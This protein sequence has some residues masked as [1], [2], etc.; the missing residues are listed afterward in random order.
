MW[1]TLM[2]TKY[3]WAKIISIKSWRPS[4]RE[5]L[6]WTLNPPSSLTRETKRTIP[7]SRPPEQNQGWETRIQTRICPTSCGDRERVGRE[8][9]HPTFMIWD[10]N[11]IFLHWNSNKNSKHY[12]NLC[13]LSVL[14]WEVSVSHIF[15][16]L[17]SRNVLYHVHLIVYIL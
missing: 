8:H 6:P 9:T 15:T 13:Y 12:H 7:L 17:N 4:A 1:K 10:C 16:N 11:L 2:K 5:K 14:P 3:E